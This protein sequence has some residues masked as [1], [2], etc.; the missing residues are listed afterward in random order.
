M[1][2]AR[3]FIIN[4]IIIIIIM[5]IPNG[6]TVSTRISY[7]PAQKPEVTCTSVALPLMVHTR[8]LSGISPDYVQSQH[9]QPPWCP[10]L[11]SHLSL[12]GPVHATCDTRGL[13]CH[14]FQM[15]SNSIFHRWLESGRERKTELWGCVAF[16][17]EGQWFTFW[18]NDEG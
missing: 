7:F 1:I 9:R 2:C 14:P 8:C 15:A 10:H 5:I 18:G 4:I 11:S 17:R 13:A 6:F 3:F 16:G 12:K